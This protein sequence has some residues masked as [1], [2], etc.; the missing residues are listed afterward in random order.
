MPW[1]VFKQSSCV[2]KPYNKENTCFPVVLQKSSN[3]YKPHESCDMIS[4][5]EDKGNLLINPYADLYFLL[6]IAMT[7]MMPSDGFIFLVLGF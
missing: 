7:F 6:Y 2:G 3:P 1:A 5:N 4:E